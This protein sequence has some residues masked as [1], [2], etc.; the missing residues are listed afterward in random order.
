M[1]G[2]SKSRLGLGLWD[3]GGM[4]GQKPL[5]V[6]GRDKV[7]P[8]KG[9]YLRLR[10]CSDVISLEKPL[11]VSIWLSRRCKVVRLL[12]CSKPSTF[13]SMFWA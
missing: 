12:R 9:E 8:G 2:E 1:R 4:W 10:Y 7:G 13:F 6:Q 3:Q 5:L 11:S